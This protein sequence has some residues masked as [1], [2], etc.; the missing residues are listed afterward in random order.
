MDVLHGSCRLLKGKSHDVP[1]HSSMQVENNVVGA[2][3]GVMDQM[4]AVLG[5]EGALM[6]MI[7]QPAEVEPAV[8][9]PGHLRLWG[10]DSGGH[11]SEHPLWT[12]LWLLK[13][14]ERSL[15]VMIL[16]HLH[17]W[18]PG[19]GGQ[20]SKRCCEGRGISVLW[21]VSARALRCLVKS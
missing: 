12:L 14:Q 20:G 17:M 13:Q 8:V 6:A 15:L 16:G 3:C 10:L 9:I 11:G 1:A 19:S 4:A 2:P 21:L 7:C 5:E 18:G